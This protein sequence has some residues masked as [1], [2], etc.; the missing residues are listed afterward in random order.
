M[1]VTLLE[2][3]CHIRIVLGYRSQIASN[4]IL[5]YTITSTY[6]ILSILLLCSQR[7]SMRDVVSTVSAQLST[8]RSQQ[9]VGSIQIALEIQPFVTGTLDVG[10]LSTGRFHDLFET[11][12]G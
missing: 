4:T 9:S 1:P 10:Q 7:F 5:T 6:I 2:E 11:L 8:L 12:Q 3:P